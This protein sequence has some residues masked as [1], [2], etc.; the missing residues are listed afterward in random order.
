MSSYSVASIIYPNKKPHLNFDLGS[1][2][3]PLLSGLGSPITQSNSYSASATYGSRNYRSSMSSTNRSMVSSYRSRRVWD[4]VSPT[5]GPTTSVTGHTWLTHIM[6]VFTMSYSH[7]VSQSD[8][9][10]QKLKN[11]NCTGSDGVSV[12]PL[13]RVAQLLHISSTIP[14]LSFQLWLYDNQRFW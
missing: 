14:V 3:T 9:L 5:L 13:T 4:F 1:P 6:N 11:R 7:T 2:V 10:R 8:C 12:I